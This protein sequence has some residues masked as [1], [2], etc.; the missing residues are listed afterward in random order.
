MMAMAV[1]KLYKDAQVTIGPWIERGFY[2]DFDL[3]APLTEKELKLIKK[4]MQKIARAK[5]PFIREDV[6]ARGCG[7]MHCWARTHTHST[8]ACMSATDPAVHTH[9]TQACRSATDPACACSPV[10][11][12][13]LFA[14]TLTRTSTGVSRLSRRVRVPLACMSLPSSRKQ[15][16]MH[17]DPLACSRARAPPPR[18][19]PHARR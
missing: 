13:A 11:T 8:Q 4:E 17:M 9:S 15:A 18:R 5:L 12:R 7:C 1:Q 16:S 19:H 6:S 10:C 14:C 2:Y 3:K